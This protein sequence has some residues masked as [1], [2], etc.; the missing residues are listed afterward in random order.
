MH[1]TGITDLDLPSTE[2]GSH[3]FLVD[4]AQRVHV[5]LTTHTLV[6]NP[7]I[8]TGLKPRNPKTGLFSIGFFGR[9]Y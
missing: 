9:P 1:M 6:L 5:R 4:I 3:H 7:S 8:G 2:E